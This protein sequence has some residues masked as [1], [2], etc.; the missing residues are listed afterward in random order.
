MDPAHA[1]Q[2]AWRRDELVGEGPGTQPA[3]AAGGSRE[4][5]YY[6]EFVWWVFLPFEAGSP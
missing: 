2:R 3:Q 5:C 6:G 4:V 1:F